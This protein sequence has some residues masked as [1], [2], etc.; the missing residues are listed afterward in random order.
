MFVNVAQLQTVVVVLRVNIIA[1]VV[2]PV[3]CKLLVFEFYDENI[4]NNVT[5]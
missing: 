3:F 4:P 1:L 2:P 5:E